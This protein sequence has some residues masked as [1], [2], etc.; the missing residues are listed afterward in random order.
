MNDATPI[1]KGRK[2]D[3]VLEG[4]RQVFLA[5]GYEGASVDAIARAAGVSK[6][7]LYS[8]FAD[9]RLLFMEVA[10]AECSL[11]IEE[12]NAMLSD[13]SDPREVL[14]VAAE[15]MLSF[16]LSEFGQSIFRMCVAESDRFPEL[17]REFYETGPKHFRTRMVAYLRGAVEEGHLVI[18]DLELAADQFAELC[19]SSLFPE[20]VFGIRKSATD[21]EKRRVIDGA[22]EMFLARYGA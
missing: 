3:Q 13:D 5:D 11:Q 7:T 12:A 4:A 2:F 15:R 14:S 9:K 10:K 8:Y 22:V 16:F 19:K 6:A 20:L 21:T 1:K 17:G 18:D